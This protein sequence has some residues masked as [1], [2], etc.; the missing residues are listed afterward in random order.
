MMALMI[1]KLDTSVHFHFQ[2]YIS[3]MLLLPI[4]LMNSLSTSTFFLLLPFVDLCG[5]DISS[6]SRNFCDQ[7]TRNRMSSTKRTT[8]SQALL[9]HSATGKFQI[10]I[11]G[12]QRSW[13]AIKR[14]KK[15]FFMFSSAVLRRKSTRVHPRLNDWSA[16]FP[17]IPSHFVVVVYKS[18]RQKGAQRNT[19]SVMIS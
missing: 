11:Y 2:I 9:V 12:D 19:I 18:F 5:Y 3:S 17:I 16:L 1:I 10:R 13:R 7:N 14:G 15:K 4:S 8:K 6:L